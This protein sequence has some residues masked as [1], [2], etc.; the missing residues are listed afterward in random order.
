MSSQ[1]RT[2]P[3]VSHAP[4]CIMSQ[5]FISDAAAGMKPSAVSVAEQERSRLHDPMVWIHLDFWILDEF[6][7]W[8]SVK[9]THTHTQDRRMGAAFLEPCWPKPGLHFI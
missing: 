8:R 1:R 5:A 4:Q 3:W 9:D 6:L 7:T 2:R